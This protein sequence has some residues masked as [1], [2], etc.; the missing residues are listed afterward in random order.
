MACPGVWPFWHACAHIR[1]I[2]IRLTGTASVE[3]PAFDSFTPSTLA[4]VQ[5]GSWSGLFLGPILFGIEGTS[6]RRTCQCTF[7]LR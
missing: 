6:L 4:P 5:I 1:S 2:A 3:G 7:W